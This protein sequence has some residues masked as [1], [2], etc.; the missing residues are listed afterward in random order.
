MF[1]EYLIRQGNNTGF[2]FKIYFRIMR[3]LIVSIAYLTHVTHHHQL[4][5]SLLSLQPLYDVQ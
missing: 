1:A 4:F 2:N 5:A 3:L